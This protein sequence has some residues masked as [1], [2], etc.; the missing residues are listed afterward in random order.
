M[1]SDTNCPSKPFFELLAVN[2][3]LPLRFRKALERGD[4]VLK[5]E[6]CRLIPFVCIVKEMNF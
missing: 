2:L 1:F 4:H 6:G 3:K 5:S